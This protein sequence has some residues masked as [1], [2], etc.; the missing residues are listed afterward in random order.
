MD[1]ALPQTLFH[2]ELFEDNKQGVCTVETLHSSRI[3]ARHVC[4][5]G[6]M[7]TYTSRTPGH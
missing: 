3:S 1:L 2:Q 7:Q 6:H 5:Y 4:W